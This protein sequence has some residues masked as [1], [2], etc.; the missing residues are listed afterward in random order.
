M[1]TSADIYVKDDSLASNPIVGAVVSVLDTAT[2]IEVAQGV[3]SPLGKAS[4]LLPGSASPG[5]PYEVRVYK[6][7]VRFLNPFQILVEEPA[8]TTNAFDVTGTALSIPASTD[9]RTCRCTGRFMNFSNLPI[10]GATVRIMALA[11]P[12]SQV[13]KTVDGNLISAETMETHTDS[14][15]KISLDLLRNG[16]YR[17]TFSGEDD[18]IWRIKVPDRPSMNLI[19]MIHPQPFGIVWDQTQ[20]PGNAVSLNVGVSKQVDFTLTLTDYNTVTDEATNYVKIMNSDASII[21]VSV[22][23]NQVFISAKS[24]GTAQIT[25]ETVDNLTPAQIPPASLTYTALSVTVS[26]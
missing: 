19:D 14:D 20:A 22:F 10:A 8:V 18:V 25:F 9:P 3:T 24:P 16:E 7:G 26:P 12:G 15:G 5:T 4:F 6:L 13:P 23:H 17:I 1:A 2:L 21:D 11:Y